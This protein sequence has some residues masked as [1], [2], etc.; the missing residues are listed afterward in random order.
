MTETTHIK[1]EVVVRFAGDSGDGIQLTGSQFTDSTAQSGHDLGTYPDFPAEIR[2]PA[3]TVPGVSGFQINFGSNAIYT[4]GDYCDV[5]VVMNAAALKSNLKFIKEEGIVIANEDGFDGKNLQQAGYNRDDT[6]LADVEEHYQ[7]YRVP[8]T[9]LTREALKETEIKTKERDRS[10]NMFVLGLIYWLFNRD[11]QPTIDFLEDKFANKPQLKEANLNALK[12]GFNYGDTAEIFTTRYEV[13]P[14]DLEK[15]TYRS[16][17][18]NLATALGLISASHKAELPLFYGSYP[19]TPA[20]DILHELS[21]HKNFDVRTFQAEDEISAIS[22]VIGASYGGS[23]AIT[24]TSGPGFS[25]K[26]EALGL[27]MNLEV[28]LVVC[29]IQ[30]AGPS[31]GMPTKMEQAD[32]MQALYGRHGEAPIPVLA[33]SQPSDCFDMAFEACRIAIEYMTPVVFLGDGYLANGSE[34]WRFPSSSDLPKIQK[35]IATEADKQEDKF[36]PYQRD[37][38]L[39]RKWALPGTEGFQ[40]RI[41]G[42]EKADI[43][44]NV[45][46]DPENHQKM[47]DTRA[48]K[49]ENVKHAIPA[50]TIDNGSHSGDVLLLGWGSTY[51]VLKSA[52]EALQ[53]EG[54]DV[55]HAHVKYLNPLPRNLENIVHSFRHVI[56]PENNSGQFV[57]VIR[58]E[59]LVPAIP[60]NKV[61]GIPFTLGEITGK[62]K[63]VLEQD[64]VLG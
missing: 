48:Q 49:V 53:K 25:L 60:F 8:I 22:A 1:N 6:P 63:A 26:S 54:I 47:V 41:G 16:V 30:R 11:M 52:T 10:K 64:K 29:N 38:K 55:A 17:T 36:E 27:A 56:V 43:T 15:G 14:A 45:S 23:L 24:G 9:K 40:N 39:V 3:G 2:A 44:G 59:Y 20:S 50:Q 35:P 37:E 13:K 21:K 42:L 4:P 7:L 5:L 31:T 12:A 19:I 62:V 58:N 61:Q 28:P 51:G 46:Y 33:P 57:K 32:L 18:G 34:P